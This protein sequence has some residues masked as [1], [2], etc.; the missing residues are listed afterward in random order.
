MG[1]LCVVGAVSG[2]GNERRGGREGVRQGDWGWAFTWCCEKGDIPNSGHCGAA[3]ERT[4]IAAL[5]D[6]AT[7]VPRTD[8]DRRTARE[9]MSMQRPPSDRQIARRDLS[10]GPSDSCA[11]REGSISGSMS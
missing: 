5:L 3:S 6:K 7:G 10:R 9:N 1:R 11:G 4:G 2:L 8:P